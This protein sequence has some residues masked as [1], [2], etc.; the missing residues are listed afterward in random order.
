M[1]NELDCGP[2]EDHPAH[3][4]ILA[5]MSI[6]QGG[7]NP[8]GKGCAISATCLISNDQSFSGD[9]CLK[10]CSHTTDYGGIDVVVAD[11][12]WDQ[13]ADA[14]NIDAPD[15]EAETSARDLEVWRGGR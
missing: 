10:S 4:K 7:E 8:A 3:I 5:Q 13:G 2:E 14:A 15:E 12:V 9:G 11:D 1:T 6:R